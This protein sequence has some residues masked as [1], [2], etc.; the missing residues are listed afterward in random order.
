ME[1][2]SPSPTSGPTRPDC[3]WRTAWATT[4]SEEVDRRTEVT[5]LGEGVDA[6]G[7]WPRDAIERVLACLDD[8]RD[9]ADEHGAERRIAVATSAVRDAANGDEFLAEVRERHGFDVRT[10]TGDEEARLTFLGATAGRDR[11]PGPRW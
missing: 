7:D 1:G 2:G 10:I 11:R 6:S 9:L 8:Y 3:S 5:R 4:R